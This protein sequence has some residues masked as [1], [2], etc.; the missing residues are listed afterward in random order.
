MQAYVGT[1]E[2]EALGVMRIGLDAA[3]PTATIGVLS[4][5]A[6]PMGEPDALRV[7]LVPFQGQTIQFDTP[8]SLTFDGETFRRASL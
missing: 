5:T 7:E 2:N 4:A 3:R 6:D 8:D 1:Y